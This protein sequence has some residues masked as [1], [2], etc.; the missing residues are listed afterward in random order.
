MAFFVEAGRGL[1]IPPDVWHEAVFLLGEK[2]D[3]LGKQG[4][5][6]ARIACQLSDE[7]GVFLSLPLRAPRP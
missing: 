4:K 3:F 2:G 1:Y 6:H 7:F 5:V